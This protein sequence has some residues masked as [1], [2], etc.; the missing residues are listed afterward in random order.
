MIPAK[1]EYLSP[2]TIDEVLGILSSQSG[3]AKILA[4]GHS[5]VP[6]M[7]LRL[8]MPATLVD[9]KNLRSDLAYIREEGSQIHI[10]ALTTHSEI[11]HSELIKEKCSV[12]S[13]TASVIAD[14]QVR[15]KGT[16]GGSLAHA[17]PAADYPA[18]ILALA[19]DIVIRGG[20]GE[21]TVSADK[22]FIDTFTTAVE[23]N[24]LITEVI[25]PVLKQGTGSSYQKFDNKASHFAVVGVSAVARMSG[26]N[27]DE[28]R[29][30]I[31]GAG[32]TATR[33]KAVE[34]LLNNNQATDELIS[35]ASE[36]ASD[37]IDC[38]SDIHASSDYRAHLTQVLTKRAI[39]AAV[40]NTK[41]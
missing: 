4:G 1:F 14:I 34:D 26:N 6:M 32:A 39:N 11:E 10:G 33:A 30:G 17:D 5:L 15:N 21:R 13:D 7:K 40:A 19:T 28:I 24:E 37:G 18:C 23:E 22:F 38:L 2:K 25:V 16:I 8:S 12:L 20:S 27:F 41:N 36:Q 9:M 31:T 35:K 3:D 29:I